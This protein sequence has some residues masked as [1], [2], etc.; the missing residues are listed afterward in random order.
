MCHIPTRVF[1]HAMMMS[2]WVSAEYI[3]NI[4]SFFHA[5]P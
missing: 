3:L 1:P 4:H 5:N 2:E